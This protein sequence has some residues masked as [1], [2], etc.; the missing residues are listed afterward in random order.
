MLLSSEVIQRML[1]R[2]TASAARR[3][4]LGRSLPPKH[5]STTSQPRIRH[6]NRPDNVQAVIALQSSVDIKVP[7][8]PQSA[9]RQDELTGGLTTVGQL[10]CLLWSRNR[11]S[12]Q[13]PMGTTIAA[14]TSQR[15]LRRGLPHRSRGVTPR[16]GAASCASR[17]E[18]RRMY[19]ASGQQR[20]D[21]SNPTQPS[22]WINSSAQAWLASSGDKSSL[23]RR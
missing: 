2:S 16:I 19:L 23:A 13:R 4:L 5:K 18:A 1:G 9:S 10:H 17:P 11:Q 15:Q 8:H 12:L 7:F 14:W 3:A 20:P 6:R 21:G 22:P